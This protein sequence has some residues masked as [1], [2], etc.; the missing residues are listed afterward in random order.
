ML[1]RI[2]SGIR[3]IFFGGEVVDKNFDN[4]KMIKRKVRIR[5]FFFRGIK[6]VFKVAITLKK[7]I[8]EVLEKGKKLKSV[9][10]SIKKKKF[11]F[12]F[13]KNKK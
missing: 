1:A 4:V 13:R 5:F 9:D 8:Y 3:K 10:L 7:E 2:G 6:Q 11:F 12:F